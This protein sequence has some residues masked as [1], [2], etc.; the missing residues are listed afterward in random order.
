MIL[1]SLIYS[2][3]VQ[4]GLSGRRCFLFGSQQPKSASYTA[5]GFLRNPRAASHNTGSLSN[6]RNEG[7]SRDSRVEAN[8]S[9]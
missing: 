4:S 8:G 1:R 3:S 6:R 2:L 9:L 7:D 5:L